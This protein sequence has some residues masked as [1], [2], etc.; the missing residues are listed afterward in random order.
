VENIYW[1]LVNAY[2]D[3]QAKERALEQS[4]KLLDDNKKQLEIG[5]LAPL[6]VVNAEST[7]ATDRQALISSQNTLNYQQQIIKQAIARNLNDPAL[8]AA[9]VIPTDRVSIEEIPEEKQPVDDL[10]QMAF[11]QSP[12]LEQAA[13]ALKNDEISLRGAKNGLLPTV[14][15]YGYLGGSGA[16]GTTNPTNPNCP[17]GSDCPKSTGGYGTAFQQAF[18]NNSPDKGFGF[19]VTIPIRNRTAQAEQASAL[20]Q[21]RQAELHLQQLRTQVKTNVV[22]AQFALTNDRAQV[23]AAQASR[24]FNQ[25][26]LDSEEKKLRLGAS[27]TAS[28][29]QQQ[30]NLASAESALIQATAA[31]ARDRAALYQTLASTLDHYNISLQEAATGDVGAAPVI[32]GVTAAKTGNTPVAASPAEK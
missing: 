30:R 17:S 12:V 7:V 1:G 3:Q 18:N 2:E 22:N 6:D 14:D 13:L 9:A 28:V 29:L 5:T 31:Y 21:Y 10:V 23:K 15:V 25:Q 20:I 11:K 16:A 27:T 19:N 26:S 4:S 8:V 32:P 24:D